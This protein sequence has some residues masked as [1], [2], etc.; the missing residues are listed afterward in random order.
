MRRLQRWM[1]QLIVRLVIL[2]MGV[3]LDLLNFPHIS[4]S[5]YQGLKTIN[6]FVEAFT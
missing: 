3:C 4:Y 5:V 6:M 2:L 1:A